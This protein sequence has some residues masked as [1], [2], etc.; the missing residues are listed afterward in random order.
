MKER[1]ITVSLDGCETKAGREKIRA[2]IA[3]TDIL[4]ANEA[5]ARQVTGNEDTERALAELAE[6]GPGLVNAAAREVSVPVCLSLDHGQKFEQA[7]E[8]IEAGFS[9]GMIDLSTEDFNINAAAAKEVVKAAHA[10]GV[11]V[12]AESGKIFDADSSPEKIA[13]GYTDP[14]T[15]G[16]FVRQTGI[17]S[18]AVSIGTAHG[19][20]AVKPK[21][22][23]RL[24]EELITINIPIVVHG[25]SDIP[26]ADVLEIVRPGTAKLNIDTDLMKAYNKGIIETLKDV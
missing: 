11:S 17:D 13:S 14:K 21:I 7:I 8:C 20:Y 1:G 16:E 23:F 18:L 22:N 15:A 12:E 6:M 19:T 9:G 3:V 24:L 26:D 2:L 4:I 5:Y 10:R 25:G